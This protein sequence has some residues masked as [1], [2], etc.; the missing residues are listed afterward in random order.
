M[1]R[2]SLKLKKWGS[3]IENR[4]YPTYSMKEES[5][6]DA[7]HK[8]QKRVANLKNHKKAFE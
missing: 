6:N 4:L 7:T 2:T 5:T 3:C 1:R 8:L